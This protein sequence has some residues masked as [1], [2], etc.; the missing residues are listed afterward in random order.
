VRTAASLSHP[1]QGAGFSKS[2]LELSFQN[3]LPQ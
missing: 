2:Y 3:T 1:G